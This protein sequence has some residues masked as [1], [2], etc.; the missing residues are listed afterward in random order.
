MYF[1][2]YQKIASLLENNSHSR[3][4]HKHVI[5]NTNEFQN[6]ENKALILKEAE[7]FDPE[8]IR[9]INNYFLINANQPKLI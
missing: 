6:D 5:L 7:P 9:A 4:K 1:V 2:S 3:T 8:N